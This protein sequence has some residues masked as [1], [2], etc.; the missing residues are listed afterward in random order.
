VLDV[1]K[2]A[3]AGAGGERWG[4]EEFGLTMQGLVEK[5]DAVE[6]AIG[7][8]MAAEG[9][10]YVPVDFATIR[11]AMTS[12]KSAPGLSSA[13][14]L[15]RY[16]HGIT[17]QFDKPIVEL[18]IGSDNQRIRAALDDADR[19]A[20]DRA[21]L[22]DNPNG[23]FAF[24]LEG[25]DFSRTGGCTRQ[26]VEQ[27]FSP[28]EMA[29]SYFNPVDA[30]ALQDPRA[31]EARAAYEACMSDAGFRYAH[32]DDIDRD[33]QNRFDSIVGDRDPT[34]L[35]GSDLASLEALQSDELAATAANADC[36]TRLL[37]PVLDQ[38]TSELRRP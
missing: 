9:F 35:T 2:A 17:T 10:E 38:I 11:T 12:D 21:L 33:L 1:A 28:A 36:E 4:G 18:G 32:P 20:Y 14:Y 15:A 26:A 29:A 16:G 7:R 19:V 25:E 37:E 6:N 22:G 24:A 3:A 31:I 27:V 34:T 30:L 8:C 13:E 5:T 23:T